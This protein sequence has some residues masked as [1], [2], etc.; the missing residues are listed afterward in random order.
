[1]TDTSNLNIMIVDDQR[2][3]RMLVRTSLREL[4]Y[5]NVTECG[6]GEEALR[7]LSESPAQLIISDVN[8]PKMDGLALL[9]AVRAKDELK[10]TPFIMLTGRGDVAL[11]KE[12]IQ[13][14]V[15]GYLVKPFNLGALK[16]KVDAAIGAMARA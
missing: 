8:M 6:D 14:G 12:A 16:Q 13:V 4:G 5:R 2:T 15:N 11:V 10:A 7:V 3:T 9:K 1:M